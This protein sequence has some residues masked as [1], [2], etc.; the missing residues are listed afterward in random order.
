MNIW[1]QP[2]NSFKSLNWD[3]EKRKSRERDERENRKNVTRVKKERE[4]RKKESD[5][6]LL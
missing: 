6:I 5:S 3:K 4:G 1:A 2:C